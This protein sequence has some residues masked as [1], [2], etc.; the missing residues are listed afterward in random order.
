MSNVPHSIDDSLVKDMNQQL[1]IA[2]PQPVEQEVQDVPQDDV[3]ETP[4]EPVEQ[5]SAPEPEKESDVLHGTSEKE[6]KAEKSD[7][8]ID[9]YGNP[10]AKPRVYTEDEVN[11]M[12]R[13]RFSRGKWAEQSQPKAETIAKE[14]TPDPNSADDW[15]TQ[16]ETF[17]EKTIEKRQA[18]QS[19]QQWRQQEAAR[20]AEFEAKFTSGMSKY[21]DFQQVVAGKPITDNMMLAARGLDNPAAFV[22]GAS[23]LHP[24]ELDRISRI[25][26]PYTQA[27]EVGRLHERMVKE[28][29]AA[30]STAK[31]LAAPKGDIG[32]KV[33][34]QPS[35]ESRIQQYAKQKRR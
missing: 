20:Q 15:E 28:R 34:N 31:P 18:K 32:Q 13:E 9:E 25:T 23:K 6:E 7:S 10:I 33:I 3:V 1:G 12:M 17:I 16:L 29:K 14:F 4:D 11:A 8:P 24:Q 26:D 21:Q 22:Y 2:Q 35:I 5:E 19:E 27:A 30:S